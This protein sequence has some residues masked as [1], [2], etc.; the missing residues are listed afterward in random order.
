METRIKGYINI[1]LSLLFFTYY[2]L[3]VIGLP[4]VDAEYASIVHKIFPPVEY[5]LGIPCLVVGTIFL[6]LL[7]QAYYMVIQDRKTDETT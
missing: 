6:I 4:F 2:S 5:A 3:W 7:G 1:A